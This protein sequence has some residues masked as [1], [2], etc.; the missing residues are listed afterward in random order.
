MCS[1]VQP[2]SGW[3]AARGILD[4]YGIPRRG[5]FVTLRA[6][7]SEP[8]TT[9]KRWMRTLR[10][11][12]LA[13]VVASLAACGGGGG[14]GS[15]GGGGTPTISG[16]ITFDRV[17]FSSNNNQGLSYAN[18]S[19]QPAREVIVELIPSGGG[20]A[21][22]TTT[23]DSNG[24]YV[25]TAPANT[26]AFVRARAQARRTTSPAFNLRVLN[27]TNSNALYVLD[28]AVFNT[29]STNLTKAI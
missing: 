15:G 16:R 1:G 26:S 8:V 2:T 14:G 4:T 18:T 5:G 29:G 7:G 11:A 17:P 23:T 21:L 12:G 22:A 25:L 24:N 28:G 27:N 13:F 6:H 10:H 20:T 3:Q 9:L 19:A